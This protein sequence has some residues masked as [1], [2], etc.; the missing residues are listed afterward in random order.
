MV[1]LWTLSAGVGALI[2]YGL[3]PYLDESATPAIDNIVKLTY[4]PFHRAAWALA[5]SWV[6]VACIHGYGGKLVQ[7]NECRVEV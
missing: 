3:T 5:L 7:K 4:G 6:I 2:V 1:V